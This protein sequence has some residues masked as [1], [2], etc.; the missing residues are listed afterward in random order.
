VT[1]AIS[2]VISIFLCLGQLQNDVRR[3][4]REHAGSVEASRLAD[5]TVHV[6]EVSRAM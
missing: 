3:I 4:H 2:G 6:I 1:F 5:K